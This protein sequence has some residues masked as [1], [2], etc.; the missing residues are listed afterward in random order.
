M[1]D[2]ALRRRLRGIAEDAIEYHLRHGADLLLNDRD[3][4]AALRQLG[5]TFVTLQLNG[6]L[7]GCI[8]VL[9]PIRSLAEDVAANATS[10]AFRDPRFPPL[11]VAEFAKLE[12]HI[13]VLSEPELIK[14][15]SEAELLESLRPGKDGLILS[16]GEARATYLPAVWE[17]L[18][19]PADFVRELKRKAGWS[20]DHW[21]EAMCA[22]R[23]S[24]ESF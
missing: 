3:E 13:S 16:E 9:L 7:R 2:E 19:E 8:G 22:E 20:A 18:P 11:R 23:Y 1:L 21:S 10:A 4:P 5:A 24:V 6:R 17:S 12:I 14:C 15:T